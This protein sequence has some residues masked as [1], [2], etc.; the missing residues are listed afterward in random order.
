MAEE[1]NDVVGIDESSIVV[2]NCTRQFHSA[3]GR[4]AQAEIDR[5]T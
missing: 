5:L 3:D 4:L 2:I 1:L